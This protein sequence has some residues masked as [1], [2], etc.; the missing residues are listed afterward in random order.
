MK[1]PLAVDLETTSLDPATGSILTCAVSD[2]ERTVSWAVKS[3]GDLRAVREALKPS[4]PS[5]KVIVHHAPMEA[6]WS[7]IF[8]GLPRTPRFIDTA[9]LAFRVD[10]GEPMSLA[11]AVARHLPEFSGWKSST[12]EQLADPETR[13]SML[14]VETKSLLERNAIDALVTARL[15]KKLSEKLSKEE[16]AHHEEDVE[17]SLYSDRMA[18]RGMHVSEERL[19]E[20]RRECVEV[21]DREREWL[22]ARTGMNDLNPG[23]SPQLAEA[24]RTVGV[25]LPTTDA[26]NP[27]ASGLV[28]RL[29]RNDV[30]DPAVVEMVDRILRYRKAQD[31]LGDN[32]TTYAQARDPGDGRIRGGFFWPGTVSGRPSCK[33]PNRLNVPREGVRQIFEA[34]PGYA[35]LECDLSQAELR[36]M[37]QLSGDPVLIDGFKNGTD[38]H[39]RMGGRVY[40]KLDR[41]DR[42][43]DG[44]TAR[45]HR[46]HTVGPA[47]IELHDACQRRV[48]RFPVQQDRQSGRLGRDARLPHD[49]A[50][51]DA[52]AAAGPSPFVVCSC[53]RRF[54]RARE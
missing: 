27:S 8:L 24:F 38:F 50:H 13:G 3:P 19:I 25:E 54:P 31:R 40:G 23:S 34:P 46:Q 9:L 53:A 51:D 37:A 26:G 4:D 22:R 28:L 48:Q 16:L 52:K 5:E 44:A 2:G 49:R 6:A 32:V 39:R 43:L 29:M 47:L 10:P 11:S 12:N 17:I 18:R 21:M 45:L 7:E 41:L 15:E 1:P 36:I 14:G 20:L 35:F 42:T 30:K 33:A